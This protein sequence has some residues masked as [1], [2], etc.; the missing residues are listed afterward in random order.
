MT[1][2]VRARGERFIGQLMALEQEE[3]KGKACTTKNGK[4]FSLKQ[5]R[6]GL[7]KA[8]FRKL[9]ETLTFMEEN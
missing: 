5:M 4:G 3:V 8:T 2:R 1:S 6:M 9:D 7:K